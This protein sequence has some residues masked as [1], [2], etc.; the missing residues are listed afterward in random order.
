MP[1]MATMDS[2]TPAG[3]PPPGTIPDF[4]AYSR[5]PTLYA[6]CGT[7]TALML[8]LVALRLY[9]RLRYVKQLAS[10][11]CEQTFENLADSQKLTRGQTHS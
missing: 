2:N 5:A 11:D 10:D 4:N 3:I 1:Q 8:L 6:T 7:A 9:S